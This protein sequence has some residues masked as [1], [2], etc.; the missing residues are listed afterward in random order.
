MKI[1][2]S[3][4]PPIRIVAGFSYKT[5]VFVKRIVPSRFVEFVVGKIYS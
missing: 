1:I 4:N 5:L 3:K 2:N